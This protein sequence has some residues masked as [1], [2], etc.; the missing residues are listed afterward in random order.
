MRKI[1]PRTPPPPSFVQFVQSTPPSEYKSIPGPVKEELRAHLFVE[2]NGRCAYCERSLR[3]DATTTRIEHFHPQN[4]PPGSSTSVCAHRLG[5]RSTARSDVSIKNM[6]LCCLGSTRSEGDERATCDTRKGNKHICEDF[7][8]PKNLPSTA[9]SIVEV[10]QSGRVVPTVHPGDVSAAEEVVEE[11]LN[12]N[13]AALRDQRRKI[14]GDNLQAFME[15]LHRKR[16][17]RPAKTLRLEAAARLREQATTAAFA[18]TLE[19][20]AQEIET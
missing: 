18:S 4:P 1:T 8:T 6:L 3:L 7:Y 14:F 20:L 5:E 15:E 19:S 2:Q 10:R 12:L 9:D 11:V 16:G 17:H 13:A